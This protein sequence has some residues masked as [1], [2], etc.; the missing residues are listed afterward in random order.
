MVIFRVLVFFMVAVMVMF[1]VTVM[2]SIIGYGYLFMLF[3]MASIMG[4]GYLFMVRVMV[5]V[6]VR[7]GRFQMFNTNVD[8]R[9]LTHSGP[10]LI[11]PI[12]MYLF[13]I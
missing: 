9:H 10:M 11:T 13:V 12:F 2:A 3:V 5:W 6:M 8:W 7:I 4:Y 1:M